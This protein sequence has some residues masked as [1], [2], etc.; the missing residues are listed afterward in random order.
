MVGTEIP[1]V[2]CPL[3]TKVKTIRKLEQDSNKDGRIEMK[4]RP[5]LSL[6]QQQY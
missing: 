5:I 2:N 3:S 4:P 6:K 1:V